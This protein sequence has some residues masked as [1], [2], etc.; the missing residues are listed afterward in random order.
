MGIRVHKLMGYG[1]TDVKSE[2]YSIKDPR[3]NP[4][5]IIADHEGVFAAADYMTFLKKQVMRKDI[6]T[7]N[8]AFEHGVLKS[9]KTK[10]DADVRRSFVYDGEYGLD[11]V[12]VVVPFSQFPEWFRYNDTIDYTE[13]SHRGR[14]QR[15]Y[16]CI[17]HFTEI[18][19]GFHPWDNLYWDKRT[20]KKVSWSLMEH[21][22][23]EKFFAEE[24]LDKLVQMHEFS[25]WSE[26]KENAVPIVPEC[27]RLLCEW[28]QAFTDP[29]V[30]T[31]LKPMIY[32]YWS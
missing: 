5:G 27:V 31:Q 16:Q 4:Q 14:V 10:K 19:G 25:S 24:E 29:N 9:L 28:G 12:L 8:A 26:F 32:V 30:W 20:F 1:L 23:N 11:N 22:H 15:D 7:W 17:N 2:K 13:E 6:D 18:P 21:K 3:V